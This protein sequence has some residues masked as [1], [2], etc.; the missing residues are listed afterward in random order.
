[1]W[2]F[3]FLTFAF[4]WGW[5]AA[6]HQTGFV[7]MPF[8]ASD[9][10]IYPFLLI[11]MCGPAVAAL[12]LSAAQGGMKQTLRFRLKPNAWW[13]LAWSVPVAMI[14]GAW[15]VSLQIPGASYLPLE[16]ETAKAVQA[17]TGKPLPISTDQLLVALLVQMLIVGPLINMFA[18]LTEELGWRGYLLTKLAEWPFWNRHLTIGFFWGVWHAPVIAAG[19]N[20]PGEPI[21]GPIVFVLFC[22]LMSPIIGLIAER[23]RSVLAA[24]LFHGTVNA[25]APASVMTIGGLAMM[26][27]SIVGWPGLAVMAIVCALIWLLR[28]GRR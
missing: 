10:M 8:Q 3:L 6:A 15:W 21:L 18:T 12:I 28:L 25:V 27:K 9:P 14:A 22:M 16:T 20:Y 4:S 13:L 1:M 26:E 24:G 2:A 17:Q 19:Y 23:G 11:F 7:K 5:A